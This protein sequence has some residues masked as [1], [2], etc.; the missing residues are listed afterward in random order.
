MVEGGHVLCPHELEL[1]T[2]MTPGERKNRLRT[3]SSGCDG[4]LLPC[5]A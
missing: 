5:E 4:A 3:V 2:S 1:Y